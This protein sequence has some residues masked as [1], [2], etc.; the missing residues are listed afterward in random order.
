[1]I[2]LLLAGTLA[3]RTEKLTEE[4]WTVE[5]VADCALDCYTSDGQVARVR[6]WSQIGSWVSA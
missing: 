6:T 4:V 5:L 1:V 2:I 3:S